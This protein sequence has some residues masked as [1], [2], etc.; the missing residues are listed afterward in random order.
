MLE[1]TKLTPCVVRCP[2][3][4]EFQ[5]GNC[6]S[7]ILLSTVRWGKQEKNRQKISDEQV[8]RCFATSYSMAPSRVN[9]IVIFSRCGACQA[10]ISN[11]SDNFLQEIKNMKHKNSQID[12]LAAYSEVLS[13]PKQQLISCKLKN[14]QNC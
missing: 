2:E 1:I 10:D 3:V 9:E 13:K 5:D 14:I 4:N 12:I 11:L 7:A 8:Q 6:L